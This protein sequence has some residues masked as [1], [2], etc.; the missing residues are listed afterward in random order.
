MSG[1]GVTTSAQCQCG[2][3]LTEHAGH[4]IGSARRPCHAAPVRRWTVV[5]AARHSTITLTIH[6]FTLSRASSLRVYDQS[7]AAPPRLLLSLPDDRPD[8][9]TTAVTSGNRMLIE[10]TPAKDNDV[11][12]ARGHDGFIASYTAADQFTG[13]PPRG[14][15][16]LDNCKGPRVQLPLSPKFAVK[17]SYTNSIRASLA[18][19]Y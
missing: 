18:C 12:A 6:Y 3:T 15:T 19:L 10:Y 2:C 11:T 1:V 9:V 4:I 16:R 14:A 8:T 5:V 17:N 7:T 13:T